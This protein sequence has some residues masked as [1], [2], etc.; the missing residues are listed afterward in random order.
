MYRR[1]NTYLSILS[2]TKASANWFSC[3]YTSFICEQPFEVSERRHVR[4]RYAMASL[5][6][7]IT[8]TIKLPLF[9]LTTPQWRA[10]FA[11]MIVEYASE[12]SLA[13]QNRRGEGYLLSVFGT[14][15]DAL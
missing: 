4:L 8:S 11:R 14:E 6:S 3:S 12:T 9:S 2:A 13:M 7:N 15:G 10:R 5:A 1:T